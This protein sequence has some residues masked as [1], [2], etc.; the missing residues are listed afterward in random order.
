MYQI[1]TR[2]SL[3]IA[4]F[5]L[6][7]SSN[8]GI[9]TEASTF[10]FGNADVVNTQIGYS[11]SAPTQFS[12][13]QFINLA[14]FDSSVGILTGVSVT[15]SSAFSLESKVHSRDFTYLSQPDTFG[16]ATA[17][18]YLS[19]ALIN[20]HAPITA[21]ATAVQ[22]TCLAPGE[23]AEC[24]SSQSNSGTMNGAANLSSVALSA[25]LDSFIHVRVIQDLIAE[26]TPRTSN[27]LVHATN[28]NNSLLGQVEIT[29]TYD[30]FPVQVSAPP[31]LLLFAFSL[32]AIIRRRNHLDSH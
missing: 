1:L 29:Y 2:V 13:A 11:S 21:A 14:G 12:R 8:A 7:I 28:T 15:F 22:A 25:F 32:V 30:D 17:R 20:P 18:M 6:C 31:G 26:A 19:V 3:F 27:S 23:N 16:M 4:S 10:S 5:T 24:E 9:I